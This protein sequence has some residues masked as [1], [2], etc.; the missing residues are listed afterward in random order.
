M[1]LFVG[2]G[3]TT[4]LVL[5]RPYLSPEEKGRRLAEQMGCFA[6]HG[7]GGQG[8]VFNP[9]RTDVTVPDWHG[10]MM[11][12]AHDSTQIL[13]W[14][15]DGATA[16]R[17]NSQSWREQRQ[18]GALKMLAFGKR[19][20]KEQIDELVAYVMAVSG[21]SVPNDSLASRGMA[22]ADSL[23]CFGCHGPGGRLARPNA[24]SF[25]GYV[26]SWKGQD[27]ADVVHDRTEFEQWVNNG[28]SDRFKDNF[29]ARY[30]LDRAV[31]K[32]PAFHDHLNPGDL[33]ALWAYI[34]WLRSSQTGENQSEV[35]Q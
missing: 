31:L 1:A 32:M 4:W 29:L 21:S 12:F 20:S 27:F 14:I 34:Q 25:K 10:D 18:K 5:T 26:P 22:R 24:G 7:S 15:R 28:I 13:E 17:A 19:L 16:A 23:G 35:K 6:C 2:A 30:F 3:I 8:G 11:M 33:D 9:G